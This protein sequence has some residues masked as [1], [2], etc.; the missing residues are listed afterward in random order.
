MNDSQKPYWRLIWG[1]AIAVW[2]LIVAWIIIDGDLSTGGIFVA[3]VVVCLL[4]FMGL[5]VIIPDHVLDGTAK[6]EEREEPQSQSDGVDEVLDRFASGEDDPRSN[7]PRP[8][9]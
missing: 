9:R 1:A 4:A 7:G 8:N 5:A 6:P 2:M 3:G